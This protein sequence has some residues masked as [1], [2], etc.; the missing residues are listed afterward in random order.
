[1]WGQEGPQI[2][3]TALALTEPPLHLYSGCKGP[4]L[5]SSLS[6][7]FSSPLLFPFPRQVVSAQNTR[8]SEGCLGEGDLLVGIE[9]QW[10]MMSW[11]YP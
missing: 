8:N 10:D 6:L 4:V 7:F 1:M 3:P 9:D 11:R 5:P 2:G